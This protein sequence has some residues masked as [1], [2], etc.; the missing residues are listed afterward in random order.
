MYLLQT[1]G[2]TLAPGNSIGTLTVDGDLNLS[3]D[4]TTEIEFNALEADKII[5]NGDI[6]L[7][8]SLVLK[9]SSGTY[10]AKVY[11]LIDGNS[12]SGN[13]LSGTFSS[14]TVNNSSNISG[15]TTSISYDTSLRRVFLT[16]SASTSVDTIKN[17]TTISNFKDVAEIFD[18]NTGSK[19]CQCKNISYRQW[20]RFNYCK[21]RIRE[22]KRNSIYHVLCTTCIKSWSF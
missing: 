15:F 5:V 19:F 10:E 16:L 13:T 18:T 2:G 1:T 21:Q 22:I 8:G 9:P 11:T 14:T 4:D 3:D 7:D 12:G 17:K 6:S 20:N